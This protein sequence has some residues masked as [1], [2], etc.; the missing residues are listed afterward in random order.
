MAK[1]YDALESG[2]GHQI[3]LSNNGWTD[4]E[5]GLDWLKIVFEPYTA[6]YLQGTYQLL[7]MDGHD[8]HISTEFIKYAQSKKIECLC[9][10]PHTTHLLQPLDVGIFSLLAQS[11]KKHLEALTRISTYS[12]DKV[13]F[14][15]IVQK[16]RKKSISSQ[17]IESA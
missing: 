17:N 1:W 13:D 9:L 15:T 7:L 11:Y 5:R 14:F 12:I 6:L 3:L 8:S 4:N 16:A 10:L 2:Q